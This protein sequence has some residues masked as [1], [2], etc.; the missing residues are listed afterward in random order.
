MLR[1]MS[2]MIQSTHVRQ[3][4]RV[5]PAALLLCSTA[6][7]ILGGCYTI[8]RTEEDLYTITQSD[9]TI[10][11]DVHNAPGDRE[12]GTIYPSPRTV[13]IT[14][15]YVQRDSTVER[16]YPAFLR[17]GGIETASFLSGGS[18]DGAGNGL[19]GLYDLL[20]LNET[21]DTKTFTANLYRFMPYEIRLRW[22]D[23]SPNWTIGTAAFEILQQQADSSSEIDSDEA[24]LGAAPIYI[25]KRYFLREKPPYIMVVPFFGVSLFGPNHYVNVGSTL[26]IGSI[27]GFNARAYAGFAAGVTNLYAGLVNE[28]GETSA[29]GVTI[30]YVGIGVSALDFVN[31]T[32]E[33]F[34]EWKDHDHNALEVSGLNIDLV[35]AISSERDP[36][37]TVLEDTTSGPPPITGLILRVASASIPMPVGDRRWFVGT[38]LFNLM[39]LNGTDIAFGFLPIRTGYRF[40]LLNDELNLEPFAELT[41]FPSTALHM[42]GRLVLEVPEIPEVGLE[43]FPFTMNLVV[44]V[45]SGSTNLDVLTGV[46][47]LAAPDSFTTPYVGFGIGVG[48]ALFTPEEVMAEPPPPVDYQ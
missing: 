48:N 44:G 14:R 39:A 42:G 20:T 10:R 22:F 30:P 7:T 3:L 15:E 4:L 18:T 31:K 37:A 19:F 26:D 33:L 25:R 27:G 28:A 23:D 13:T 34:I 35:R 43:G 38:S 2:L 8:T 40:D 9:T 47:E 36:F 21:D 11:E 32:E 5:L 46:E 29:T 1:Y 41:Y 12:G 24:L 45:V 6:G 17:F 16:H